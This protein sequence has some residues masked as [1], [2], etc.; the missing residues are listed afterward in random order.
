MADKKGKLVRYRRQKHKVQQSKKDNQGIIIYVKIGLVLRKKSKRKPKAKG[1][2][3]CGR[4][5]KEKFRAKKKPIA[6]V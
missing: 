3:Y 1:L 2:I 4:I 6:V 5:Y